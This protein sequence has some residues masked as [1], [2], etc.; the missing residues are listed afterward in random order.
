MVKSYNVGFTYNMEHKRAR[1]D[2]FDINAEFDS[3]RTILGIKNAL[4]LG[5]HKVFS[6][7]ANKLIYKKLL[8][9]KEKIDIIFNIAEGYSGD[10]RESIYPIFFEQLNIPYTG[11]NPATL[12]ITLNKDAAKKVWMSQRIPTPK[13]L[14]VNSL[15]DLKD[16]DLK[17]PVII[18]PVHEGTSKGIMNDS[19][20]EN[21]PD[22]KK[23]IR[24]L[25]IN[26]KQNA[27]IEEFIHGR[28]FTVCILGNNN[29]TVFTPVE[30]DLSYLPEHL[31]QFCSYEVK[32]EYDRFDNTLCSPKIT[33][34]EEKALKNIG[35]K[36]YKAV[37]CRD[38]GRC[39]MRMDYEGN[40]YVIEINPLPGISS[41][42]QVNHSFPKAA[43]NHG[44]TYTTF[45][46]E[47]LNTALKRY[48]MFDN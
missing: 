46:N 11:S 27:I 2:P 4:E 28:E 20:V 1:D 34:E 16:F 32:M 14:T 47:I 33:L 13:F 39:D 12:S 8:R 7:E 24:Y 30:I 26:Y 45:I 38:F 48:G 3:P 31:H 5:G 36:A 23:K 6:I 9:L 43:E 21:I 40:I 35:L 37:K 17:F 42:P 18:K 44:F 15:N 29:Y 22:L 19:Y 25:L 41:D 10:S